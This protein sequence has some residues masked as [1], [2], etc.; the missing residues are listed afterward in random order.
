MLKAYKYRIYPNTEQKIFLHKCLGFSRFIYNKMLHDKIEHYKKHQEMLQTNQA[1]YKK[2]FEFLKEVDSLAL[3]SAY[4]NLK[5]SFKNFFKRHETGFPNFKSKKTHYFSYTTHNQ[6]G[7]V[8]VEKGKLKIPKLKLWIKIKQHRLFDG[9]IKSCTLS[10]TP[11]NKYYISMLIESEKVTYL[12]PISNHNLGID[13]GFKE[14][15]VCSNGF[16][17]SNPKYLRKS[18]HKLAKAQRR[19]SRQKKGSNNRYKAR[20]K[21]AIIYDK[22]NNQS[23][24]FL[25]K[26]STKL[27]RE[28]QSIA[29]ENLKIIN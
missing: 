20:I 27:I 7:T 9:L 22:I 24:D 23:Y 5:T 19:L 15:C 21:V 18:E 1:S 6:K 28:N 17:I 13:V 11:S 3:T 25:H 4:M 10:K 26:L 29:I 14:F 12:E 16:R 2:E 8:K